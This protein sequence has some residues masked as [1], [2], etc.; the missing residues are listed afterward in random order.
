VAFAPATAGPNAA[1]GRGR[2]SAVDPLGHLLAL[3]I[4]S[5]SEGD[6]E[7]AATLAQQVTDPTVELAGVP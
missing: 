2:V 4:T 6:R 5:A 1:N 7:Q 3:E